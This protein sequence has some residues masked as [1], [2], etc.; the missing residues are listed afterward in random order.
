MSE[1]RCPYCGHTY[2]PYARAGERQ[3]HCGQSGCRRKPRPRVQIDSVLGLARQVRASIL[4]FGDVV[5]RTL[6]GEPLK[7]PRKNR[8]NTQTKSPLSSRLLFHTKSVLSSVSKSEL[9]M[10]HL[11][12]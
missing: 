7:R 3:K 12:S 11:I 6:I 8:L 2:E 10:K 9:Q 1:K 4:C 5:V